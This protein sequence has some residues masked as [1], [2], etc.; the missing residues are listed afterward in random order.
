MKTFKDLVFKKQSTGII[1]GVYE[2]DSGML[3]SV[4]AGSFAYSTP[5]EDLDSEKDYSSFEVAVFNKEGQFV[6][7]ELSHSDNDV[8]GWRSID[9]INELMKSLQ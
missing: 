1:N 9:D 3:I 6:T 4:S 5:R 8:S 2:F 7:K